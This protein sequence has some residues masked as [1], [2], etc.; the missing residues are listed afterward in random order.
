MSDLSGEKDEA[1]PQSPKYERKADPECFLEI[2]ADDVNR[3]RR[4]VFFLSDIVL[5]LR[6]HRLVVTASS[7]GEKDAIE[8][9][10]YASQSRRLAGLAEGEKLSDQPYSPEISHLDLSFEAEISST[11]DGPFGFISENGPSD[12]EGSVSI[13]IR[14]GPE[15]HSE[16]KHY[17][18][19]TYSA[20][21]IFV[22]VYLTKQRLEWLHS[23]RL[24]RPHLVPVLRV[25]VSAFE[26]LGYK[27]KVFLEPG[28]SARIIRASL[29]IS[30]ANP[31][32]Q[33]PEELSTSLEFQEY[34]RWISDPR[35]R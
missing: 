17:E 18:G 30:D 16:I 1:V 10:Q 24:A 26:Q 33:V 15:D 25:T 20:G 32:Q 28:S 22:C 4:T 8:A 29:H 7:L 27:T 12:F 11:A 35:N 9:S 2:I 3:E 6:L 13:E 31:R 21:V 5:N 19:N 34:K 23:E 14:M